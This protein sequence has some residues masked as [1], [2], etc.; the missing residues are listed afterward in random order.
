MLFA[1]VLREL[2]SVN[3]SVPRLSDTAALTARTV[4]QPLSRTCSARRRW[5]AGDAST[6]TTR[7]VSPTSRAASTL[8]TPMLAP[9]STKPSPGR[10]RL[11]SQPV[12]WGSQTPKR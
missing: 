5:Q 2:A 10:R 3:V 8:K 12:I 4:R 9:T 1:P 7:P 6:A 11:H